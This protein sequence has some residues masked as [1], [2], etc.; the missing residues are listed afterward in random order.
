MIIAKD[1]DRVRLLGKYSTQSVIRAIR[2]LAVGA[3]LWKPYGYQRTSFWPR[4]RAL[5]CLLPAE[6]DTLEQASRAGIVRASREPTSTLTS[7]AFVRQYG[8]NANADP[9]LMP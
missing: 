8:M 2:E 1:A 9:F 6:R 4:S 3:C 7:P 5:E